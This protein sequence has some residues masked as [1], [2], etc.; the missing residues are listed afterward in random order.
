MG[1]RWSRET[2][3]P[4][5]KPDDATVGRKERGEKSGARWKPVLIEPFRSGYMCGKWLKSQSLPRQDTK[6]PIHPCL[7]FPTT[8]AMSC[9]CGIL[10]CCLIGLKARLNAP[11]PNLV[12]HFGSRMTKWSSIVADEAWEQDGDA[13]A[14]FPSFSTRQGSC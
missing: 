3:R 14:E 13:D 4:R 11:P 8:A 12:S 1:K 10:A 7:F 5:I 9:E 2:V 6:P